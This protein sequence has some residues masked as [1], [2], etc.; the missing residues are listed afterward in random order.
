[1]ER[2]PTL[3]YQLIE[4]RLKRPPVDFI[5]E[6]REAGVS[7]RLIAIE[8]TKTTKVDVTLEAVRRWHRWHLAGELGGKPQA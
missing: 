7:Y 3:K 4:Q 5:V 6:K 2:E 1:M 8:L